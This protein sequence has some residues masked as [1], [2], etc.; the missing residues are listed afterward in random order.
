MQRLFPRSA[1]CAAILLTIPSSTILCAGTPAGTVVSAAAVAAYLDGDRQ[2][3]TASEPVAVIV[4]PTAGVLLALDAVPEKVLPGRSYYVGVASVNA[5]NQDDTITLRAT[6]M[7]GWN[8]AFVRDDNGDGTHQLTE[9][10]SISDTGPLAPDSAR[11]CFLQVA[12]P[13]AAAAGDIITISASSSYDPDACTQARVEFPTP[14]AHT[15]SFAQRPQISPA[16]VDS[17]GVV[18]CTATAVDT[19]NDELTYT[20]S[21]GGA[22]GVF[23][24]NPYC[25]NPIYTA[26]AN[27]SGSDISINITCTATCSLGTKIS[28]AVVP[29]LIVHPTPS[30][31]FDPKEVWAPIG[32]VFQTPRIVLNDPKAP[33]SVSFT[34]GIPIG[35]NLDTTVIDKSLACIRN[36]SGVDKLEANWDPDSRTISVRAAIS[37]PA[38]CVEIIKSMALTVIDGAPETGLMIDGRRALSILPFRPAPGDFNRD[39]QIDDIDVAL[40][41]QKWLKWHRLPPPVFNPAVDAIFDLAP[42]SLGIWPEWTPIGDGKVN[43]L[44]ATAFIE[45]CVG[46]QN[47]A[48]IYAGP[49]QTIRT[50]SLMQVTV[51]SA[52][53][54]VFQVSIQLPV[55]VGFDPAIDGSGNLRYVFKGIDVGSLFYSEFDPASRT[56]WLTGNVTGSPPFRVAS[57]FLVP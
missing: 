25:P 14:V 16:A 35:I 54:G 33:Q 9:T 55:G 28:Q 24:P 30:P 38:A 19:L 22:G 13:P 11:R 47:K 7:Q 44:D 57:V 10:L 34:I 5:G 36:G 29:A 3:E 23:S 45:C 26:P 1:I 49:V 2:C 6:S 48:P 31:E 21:D 53:Y 39:R 12:V 42:R 43:I 52:P 27:S 15:V 32:S 50:F 8:V 37:A 20:W 17:G 18:W 4:A 41:S 51:P 46:S 56:L 40:F